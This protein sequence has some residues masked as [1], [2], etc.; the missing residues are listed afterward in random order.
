[1]A[2]DLYGMQ[3]HIYDKTRPENLGFLERLRS[4]TEQYD[5]I[6][7]VG[8]VGEMGRR[9]SGLW[10]NTRPGMIASTWPIAL[11]CLDPILVSSTFVVP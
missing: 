1:M 7:M 2:T 3:Q 4:L 9:S 5:D 6:M 11:R 10:A 8:E